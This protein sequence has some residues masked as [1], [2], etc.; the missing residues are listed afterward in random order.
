MG[1]LP[2]QVV[3]EL[4]AR[5]WSHLATLE[6]LNTYPQYRLSFDFVLRKKGVWSPF[7]QSAPGDKTGAQ[8]FADGSF[9]G[10][11]GPVT[12]RQLRGGGGGGGGSHFAAV[13]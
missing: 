1:A 6:S 10:P 5:H 7:D 8:K 13:V 9:I 2:P 4:F 11:V 12:R 3:C